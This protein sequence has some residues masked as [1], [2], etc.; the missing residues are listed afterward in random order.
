LRVVIINFEALGFQGAKIRALGLGFWWILRFSRWG[1]GV[2]ELGFG[3]WNL[4]FGVFV[5]W[6]FGL[7]C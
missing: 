7:W 6:G 2:W 3:V 5:V 4:G 1:F